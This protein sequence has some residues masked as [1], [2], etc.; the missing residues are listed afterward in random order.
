M[1]IL[2]F[3][4]GKFIRDG[5]VVAPVFG[6][7]EQIELLNNLNAIK[8][9]VKDGEYVL[10][11]WESADGYIIYFRCT[12]GRASD[13]HPKSIVTKFES[14]CELKL[15]HQCDCGLSWQGKSEEGFFFKFTILKPKKEPLK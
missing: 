11:N 4:D 3:I 6:D 5:Q 14:S 7:K 2:Q 10:P 9:A 12:C 8:Q 1:E 15:V 13:L